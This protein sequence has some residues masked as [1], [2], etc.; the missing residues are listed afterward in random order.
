LLAAFTATLEMPAVSFAALL[1]FLLL[2]RCPVR[3]LLFAVPA[4][5][6]PVIGFFLTNYLAIG[7]VKPVQSEFGSDWYDFPGSN[8]HSGLGHGIDYA[9]QQESRAA[10]VFQFLVG[11]HGVFSLTPVWL[12]AFAGMLWGTRKLLVTVWRER[13]LASL[14]SDKQRWP[15]VAAV[16]LAV[17]LAV[18]VFYLGFISHWNYGGGTS[19]P[20]WLIWLTPLWL[21]ALLP[22]AD[23]LA[24]R[25][26]GRRLAYVVLAWSVF[27]A[28]YPLWNPWRHPWLYNAM[29]ALGWHPYT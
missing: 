27:S 18:L 7:Q 15:L 23:W 5:A 12:L 16:G 10:Y 25:R 20:R 28:T 22:V 14:W 21:L 8:F 29:Q 6:L 26:W 17:S 9:W 4:A 3:T 2:L 1:L 11:H 19:G 13:S 24:V